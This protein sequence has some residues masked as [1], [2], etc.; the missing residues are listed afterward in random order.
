[1][2]VCLVQMYLEVCAACVLEAFSRLSHTLKPLTA[3]LPGLPVVQWQDW[4]PGP[5][6]GRA[7]R[8]VGELIPGRKCLS[9]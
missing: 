2:L 6:N 9:H 5:I 8:N 4:P 1:M 7:L 3:Q